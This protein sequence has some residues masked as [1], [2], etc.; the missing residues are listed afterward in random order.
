MS[1]LKDD[2][3]WDVAVKARA[4]VHEWASTLEDMDVVHLWN[5]G[6]VVKN[7]RGNTAT[8]VENAI[9][10][11][12]YAYYRS[13]SRG[14]G[15]TISDL[16]KLL[17]DAESWFDSAVEIAKFINERYPEALLAEAAP[18]EVA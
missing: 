3:V 10:E 4:D 1:K 12:G 17:D 8:P 13:W 5:L 2:D 16:Q 9:V 15:C 7:D 11:M 6:L 18:Q 14:D